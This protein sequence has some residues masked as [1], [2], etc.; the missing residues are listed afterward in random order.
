MYVPRSIPL[1]VAVFVLTSVLTVPYSPALAQTTAQP[2]PKPA[3]KVPPKGPA[4]KTATPPKAAT[5]ALPTPPPVPPPPPP[6]LVVKIRYTSGETVTTSTVSTRGPRQRIDY[7][8]DLAVL[9]QCG[10]DRIIQVNDQT[11]KYLSVDGRREPDAGAD[12]A[13]KGARKGGTITYTTTATDSGERKLLVGLSARHVKTVVTK[14]AT[15]DACDTRSET[16]ETDGWFVEPPV[17]ACPA[18]PRIA[19]VASADGCRDT[20]EYVDAASAPSLGYPLAYTVATTVGE[21]KDVKRSTLSMEVTD[22]TRLTLAD[23][24][25]AVPDGYAAVPNL[26]QLG[27]PADGTKRPGV[28]RACVASV[29]SKAERDVSLDKLSDA[30][31]VSLGD[32]GL[33][34]VRLSARAPADLRAETQSR[35]CDYVLNTEIADV[36]KP[37]KGILGRVS[38][39]TDGFGAKVDFKLIA[40]GGA[41]PALSSS[42]RSGGSTLKTVIGVAKVVSRY[43]TPIGLLGAN[44]SSMNVFAAVGG[45]VASPAMTQSH[46]AV[47]ST[48][49][50]LVDKATGNKPELELVNEEAAVASA[51]E[52]EV[53]SV[54]AFLAKKKQ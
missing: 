48:V 1:G 25:F 11:R 24:L 16:V 22:L 32:A 45:G 29:A 14:T 47:L 52:K 50:M 20:V 10:V 54:A 23:A 37:G 31:V 7:G 19:A 53:K 9:Q 26:A 12:G 49:F 18:A 5:P 41:T 15:P 30:L 27:A 4:P 6:D 8:A 40:A 42:E 46:D 21:G 36:R 33:D 39:T 44:F 35:E 43:V 38:G 2:P 51:L 17:A 13:G 28:T 34:A 3:A